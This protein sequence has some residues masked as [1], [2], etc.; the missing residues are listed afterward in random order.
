[1]AMASGHERVP[2]RSARGTARRHWWPALGCQSEWNRLAKV[3][4]RFAGARRP[5]SAGGR[6]AFP[7]DSEG[8]AEVPFSTRLQAHQVFTSVPTGE[9]D[10]P[11]S[12]THDFD[13]LH[14]G[15]NANLQRSRRVNPWRV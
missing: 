8:P 3:G 15:G 13:S 6:T 5:Q 14:L 11:R 7:A 12:F 2:A 4:G 1:M 9:V 10:S